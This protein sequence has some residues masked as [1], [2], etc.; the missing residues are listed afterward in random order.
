MFS[1]LA[2]AKRQVE[3]GAVHSQSSQSRPLTRNTRCTTSST[4]FLGLDT[5]GTTSVAVFRSRSGRLVPLT[6]AFLL[7]PLTGSPAGSHYRRPF[8]FHPLVPFF[9]SLID[10]LT[11][12]FLLDP[13][14]GASTCWSPF[15][16]P[17]PGPFVVSFIHHL[18]MALSYWFAVLCPDSATKESVNRYHTFA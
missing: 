1:G 13:R 9:V 15:F 5:C 8:Q 12:P 6:G 18:L 7:V 2:T 14:F 3:G 16:V 11:G 10:S 17:P 4:G